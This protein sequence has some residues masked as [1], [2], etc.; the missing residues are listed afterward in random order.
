MPSLRGNPFGKF[1]NKGVMAVR[2][3]RAQQLKA[4]DDRARRR[5]ATA[6]TR[7]EQSPDSRWAPYAT[8]ARNRIPSAN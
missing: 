6:R 4:A 8:G 2:S 3:A 1:I 7:A 5:I